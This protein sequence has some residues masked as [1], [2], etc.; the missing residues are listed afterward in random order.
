MQGW[1][2]GYRTLQTICSWVK[3]QQQQSGRH[4]A[5]VP[6]LAAIQRRLV[7]IGDKESNFCGSKSWIGSVEVGLV[8]D[9]LYDVCM[10]NCFTI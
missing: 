5:E 4:A 2:C 3:T 8:V 6:S 7:D 10:D 1:G 9:T